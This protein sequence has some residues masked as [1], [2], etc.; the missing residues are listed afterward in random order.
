MNTATAANKFT[1][2]M[3]QN[4]TQ[5]DVDADGVLTFLQI[6]DTHLYGPPEGK[7][8]GM[9]TRDSFL[10]VMAEVAEQNNPIQGLLE[11]GDISQDHSPQS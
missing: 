1:K 6:T 9:N 5:L 8:L 7:L 2:R 4:K 10:A 3:T 11:T